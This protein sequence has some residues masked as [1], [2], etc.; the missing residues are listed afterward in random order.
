MPRGQQ[1]GPSG[2]RS[3]NYLTPVLR[4]VIIRHQ[5]ILTTVSLTVNRDYLQGQSLMPVKETKKVKDFGGRVR[6][7][8]IAKG[9]SQS[10]LAELAGVK[11]AAISWWE[12]DYKHDCSAKALQN[13]AKALGTTVEYLMSGKE[14]GLIG[15]G[16]SALAEHKAMMR[17][18]PKERRPDARREFS[19]AIRAASKRIEQKYGH[20]RDLEK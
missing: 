2:A 6:R 16:A 7:L 3:Q 12:Q 13:A 5:N 9:M 14:E 1:W 8:R 4:W 17:T 18:L 11:K 15:I 10:E 19:Q 20:T